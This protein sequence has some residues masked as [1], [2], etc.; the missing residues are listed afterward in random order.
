MAVQYEIKSQ[1]AKLLATEDL[2]VE[3]KH[4]TSA[5]FNVH[6]RVLTL[7]LWE[8]A[9][10]NVYDV[11]VAHEVGHAL[12]TPDEDWTDKVKVPQQFVNVCEDARIEKLMKR[13]YMGLAKTFY[14]GYNELNEQ[15]F[16]EINDED[17]TTFNLADRANLYFKIGSFLP[18]DFSVTEKQIIDLIGSSETFDDT[19]K[20]AES[21][22]EYCVAQQE[23]QKKKVVDIDAH[24]KETQQE[25]D[26]GDVEEEVEE[27][28]ESQGESPQSPQMESGSE[29]EP[30]NNYSDEIA[31][32]TAASLAEQEQTNRALALKGEQQKRQGAYEVAMLQRKGEMYK[33][34]Q[35]DQ[36]KEL[37]FGLALDEE[38]AADLA[39]TTATGQVQKGVSSVATGLTG[40][41]G[42][43]G[44]FEG[45]L[46][47]HLGG[48]GQSMAGI[49]GGKKA[50]TTGASR[51]DVSDFGKDAFGPTYNIGDPSK[52]PLGNI[53]LGV[54]LS[55]TESFTPGYGSDLVRDPVT[56][57]LRRKF[58][59]E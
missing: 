17:I 1:L 29:S 10:N 47:E 45:K 34:Q 42:V 7:P 52:Q 35:E 20:A 32:Q 39:M 25:M 22:Y 36:R 53:D 6:T 33:K 15:D 49:F 5:Q 16:F 9:S 56:G 44:E 50:K 4:V 2:V 30:A 43:G 37:M 55:G 57:Q 11:L 46:G 8:L 59:W 58:P 21:L 18:L 12:Y 3:H 48:F 41:Y 31:V 14:N 38:E 27:K 24:Q 40:L 26:F 51:F 23:E 13:R 28:E 19:L 54:N